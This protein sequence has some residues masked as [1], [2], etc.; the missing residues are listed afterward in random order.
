MGCRKNVTSGGDPLVLN[1]KML[2]GLLRRL[3]AIPHVEIIRIGT[4]VPVFLPVRID[5]ELTT[6]LRQFHPLWMNI[7]FNHPKEITS[8]VSQALADH[9]AAISLADSITIAEALKDLN[10]FAADHPDTPG[11]D[12]VRALF[13][14][15]S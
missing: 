13:S 4:R 12:A 10:E 1:P 8:E 9:Q 3:R 5:Q 15:S 7:H 2:E 6:M 11:L 14:S